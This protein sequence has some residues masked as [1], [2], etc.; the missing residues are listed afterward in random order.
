MKINLND[1]MENNDNYESPKY[2]QTSL[3]AA[4]TLGF[5]KG[6]FY[7]DAKLYC[8]N[9]LLTYQDGCRANCAFCGLSKSR[10]IAGKEQDKTFIRV[11]WP[12]YKLDNIIKA[13]N[14]EK[15]NHIERVCVSMVTNNRVIDDI[16]IV[17]REISSKTNKLLSSLI[18]PTLI[19]EKWLFEL[20][21]YGT[22]K[23]D[24]AID[25]ATPKLFEQLRGAGVKGPHKWEKYW[26]IVKESLKIFKKGNVG[27]HLIVGLGETE[28]Q[29]AH[30]FQK[31]HDMGLNIH[32]FSFFPEPNSILQDMNQPGIGH[33]RSIQLLR[34][35]ISQNKIHYEN[36]EFNSQDQII[37]F[38]I[39]K[40]IIKEAIHS[41]IAFK[42][43]GCQGKTLEV[44]C[45][46]PY[47]NSTPFQAYMGEYRNF[48]IDPNH[49]DIKLIKKQLLDYSNSFIQTIENF[50]I[51]V[52]EDV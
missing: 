27:I 15:C 11:Q 34:Y 26:A 17:N 33:Y 25:A 49:E 29:M 16:I 12:I 13:L 50:K 42:T 40:N 10:K 24:I 20:E 31:A 19:N 38:G 35:L 28:E 18:S 32:L 51:I 45:N 23:V 48:P 1:F 14:S 5:K 36:L 39:E 9:L 47:A 52:K 46:R 21:R 6:K 22:D 37:D 44:A 8:V 4:M 43:S 2:L 3:A 41:G 7:R 30:I